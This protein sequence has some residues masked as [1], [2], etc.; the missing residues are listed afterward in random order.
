VG[1]DPD[2]RPRPVEKARVTLDPD[3]SQTD[4]HLFLQF[5]DQVSGPPRRVPDDGDD[6]RTD[7][8]A[9]A[10]LDRSY[11]AAVVY[12]DY[13][14]AIEERVRTLRRGGQS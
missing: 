12:D 11:D 5:V 14:D 8:V 4:V 6:E 2:R 13:L 7:D 3:G 1:T 9:R 10:V